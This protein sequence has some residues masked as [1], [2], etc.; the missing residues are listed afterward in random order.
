MNLNQWGIVANIAGTIIIAIWG[1]PNW[2][3]ADDGGTF[4]TMK[5]NV[6]EGKRYN[7]RRKVKAYLGLTVLGIGFVLQ[8]IASFYP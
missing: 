6:P 4:V 1:L 7:K 3:Y 8:L 2:Y 5:I